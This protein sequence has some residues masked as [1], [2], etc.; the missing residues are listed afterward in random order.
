LAVRLNG[1]TRCERKKPGLIGDLLTR[2]TGVVIV[3]RF[4]EYPEHAARK[5]VVWGQRKA[6][7]VLSF[8]LE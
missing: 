5:L 2:S 4:R 1:F 7:A 8:P 3:R 6:Q